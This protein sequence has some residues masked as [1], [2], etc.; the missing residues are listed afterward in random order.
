MSPRPRKA[1]DDQ[2]FMATTRVM[3]RLGPHEVTLGEIAA[4]AGL[5]ASA[6]VQRFGSKRALLLALS[7]RYARSTG[8]LFAGLRAADASPLAAIYAYGRCMA[9][10]GE[11]ADVLAHHL[12]W[13]QQ[14]IADPDFRR[15]TLMQAKASR[16][17]LH[18]LVEDAVRGGELRAETR[19]AA[20]AR[21]LEV[22]VGGSLMS[23]AVHQEGSATSWIA[24]DLGELLR[25]YL[26]ARS[27]A[28][29]NPRITRM[30]RRQQR[31]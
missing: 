22:T 21:A 28:R 31:S 10:M 16:R 12:S 17:E 3:T 6:L 20:L 27:R 14:D 7:D 19:P 9:Q 5:T 24:H 1:T 25:P 29:K 11:S 23:W 30:T 15:F 4:E 26:P 13:L 18:R 2:I 8:E